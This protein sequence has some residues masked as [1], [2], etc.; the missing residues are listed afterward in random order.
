[1]IRLTLMV[2]FIENNNN[3]N[4]NNNNNN[5]KIVYYEL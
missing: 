2:T 1:M 5:I 4:Y 3:N